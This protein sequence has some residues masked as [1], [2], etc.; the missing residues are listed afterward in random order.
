MYFSN[1]TALKAILAGSAVASAFLVSGCM[2]S[3]T[4]G[5]DK[6]ATEQLIDD[7]S[8]ITKLTPDGKTS[9][10]YTPRPDLVKPTGARA[11]PLPAPQD[12]VA[13]TSGA[14]WPESPE[15]RRARLRAEADER[16][17]PGA[18]RKNPGT[19]A[20]EEIEGGI[21][22]TSID[23]SRVGQSPRYRPGTDIVGQEARRAE[24][25]RRLA[26]NN[27]G[28]PTSRKY[29]SEPP[30]EYRQPA[31]DAPTDELGEDEW[32]KERRLKAEA[33]KKAGKTSWRDY[34]PGF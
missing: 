23:E 14:A 19:V 11:A 20:S 31:T 17:D 4:Y 3:P 28:S 22:T 16:N 34:I 12:S 10:T 18:F 27:Q 24:F 1:G 21:E 15:Q 9:I 5:T 13:S 7:V 33:R 6:T 2:S 25:K 8:N 26:E 32:K 30:L 29:L